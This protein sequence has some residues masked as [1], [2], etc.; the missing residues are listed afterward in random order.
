MLLTVTSTDI[1]DAAYGITIPAG[2]AVDKAIDKAIVK[3]IDRIYFACPNLDD[4]ITKG[5][6]KLTLAQGVVEDMVL[7]VLRNPNAYRQVSIDDYTRMVDTALSSGSLY[8]SAEEKAL[9]APGTK[10]KGI[11]SIR[12]A[13]PKWRLPG[14]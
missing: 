12:L 10:A 6:L 4:R 3:A 11:G 14:V 1:R 13:V 5:S 2:A 9:L 8:L 7:R